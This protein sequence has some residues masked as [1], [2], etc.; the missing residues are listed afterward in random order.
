MGRRY[1]HAKVLSNT[2]VPKILPTTNSRG[3]VITINKDDTRYT[4]SGYSTAC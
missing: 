2:L 1:H 4:A 3:G